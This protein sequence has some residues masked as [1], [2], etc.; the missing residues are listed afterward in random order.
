M[1]QQQKLAKRK[2]KKKK[3]NLKQFFISNGTIFMVPFFYEFPT[4]CGNL[5]AGLHTGTKCRYVAGMRNVR[6]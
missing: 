3:H 6:I 4:K 2:T 5:P 1:P